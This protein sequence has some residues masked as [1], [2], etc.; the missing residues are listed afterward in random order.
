MGVSFLAFFQEFCR[1]AK[2]TV[3]QISIVMLIFLLFLNQISGGE[4][5]E[6]EN[7]LMGAPSAPCGRKP[8]FV[9]LQNK[10]N[11][12]PDPTEY[13]LNRPLSAW[14]LALGRPSISSYSMPL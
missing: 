2:S 13:Q 1:A 8:A 10:V 3:V 11:I 14:H 4:V 7:C 12:I 6:G 9:Q 5:S